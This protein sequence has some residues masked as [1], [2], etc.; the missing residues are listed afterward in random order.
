MEKATEKDIL[1]HFG[2]KGMRW[3]VRT[4]SSGSG[5]SSGARAQQK[6]E[7]KAG[8]HK[9]FLKTYNAAAGRM[10]SH[11]IGRINNKPQY[12]NVDF[13]LAKNAK[14]NERY[15]KEMNDTFLKT[16]NEE[17]AKNLGPSPKGTKLQFVAIKDAAGNHTGGIGAIL[18]DTVKHDSV[19]FGGVKIDISSD[20]TGHI[21]GITFSS[22]T[23][24]H[25]AITR[26]E[27]F[28]EHFGIKGMRWGVRTR[29]RGSGGSTS[30]GSSG[31]NI[32]LDKHGR[33]VVDNTKGHGPS[34]DAMRA[35][36]V[37]AVAKGSGLHAISNNDLQHL[38]TR[39]NLEQQ[40]SRLT[41]GP[42]KPTKSAKI[43]GKTLK[44]GHNFVRQTLGVAKTV[45]EIHD[46]KNSDFGK[47]LK[48]TLDAKRG[49]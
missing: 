40:Y 25:D 35:A 28:L 15:L 12:K 21:T 44:N 46:F 20:S 45:K 29:S 47:M 34:Q 39:M 27:E 22:D 49:K 19:S 9:V 38:V 26:G 10:N 31:H 14:L 33:M 41:E 7:K 4:R 1:R 18:V 36:A 11:E 23:V 8:S 16:M 30:S 37:K 13:T 43:I 42:S 32:S 24:E 2:I 3:G 17:A 5:G 6:W 48:E